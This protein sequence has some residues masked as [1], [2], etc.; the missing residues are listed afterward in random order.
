MRKITDAMNA[1][2][3]SIEYFLPTIIKGDIDTKQVARQIH[4]S[5]AYSLEKGDD[6]ETAI[7]RMDEDLEHRPS[8][9]VSGCNLDG[10]RE[11]KRYLS[12]KQRDAM[13]ALVRVIYTCGG[14][15]STPP[16]E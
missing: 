3:K 13:K 2:R 7:Q 5:I 11:R 15:F 1:E 9:I 16:P 10:W 8:I 4:G 12:V 6:L 14:S